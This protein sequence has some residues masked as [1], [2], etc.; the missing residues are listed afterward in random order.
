MAA[1]RQ[2]LGAALLL[3]ASLIGAG[4]ADKPVQDDNDLAAPIDK[5]V[6]SW[7]PTKEER[8]LDMIGW[9]RDLRDAL[10]RAKESGRPI[11]LFTYSGSTERE[12]AMALQRC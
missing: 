12:N 5:C 2:K 6:Q 9:A 8:R 3:T 1:T 11:F 7:Q 10:R 4:T